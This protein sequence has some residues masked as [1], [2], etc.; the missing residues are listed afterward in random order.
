MKNICYL[1]KYISIQKNVFVF[2]EKIKIYLY[3][4]RTI[5]IQNSKIF[6]LFTF[7]FMFN[8]KSHEN[9]ISNSV[10]SKILIRIF[11][12]FYQCAIN[13][14]MVSSKKSCL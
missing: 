4:I 3:S 11:F 14:V 2:N 6:L 13:C 10:L 12:V 9:I 7:I 8:K 5:C 1:K